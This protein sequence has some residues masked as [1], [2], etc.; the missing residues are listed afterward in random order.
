MMKVLSKQDIYENFLNLTKNIY[1]NQS[2]MEYLM[3]R[4]W[5]LYPKD[6][7]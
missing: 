4:N 6:W 5:M 1:K 7:E 2:Q 3:V